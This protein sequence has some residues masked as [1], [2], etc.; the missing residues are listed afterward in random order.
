DA[1]LG[2]RR[3][4]HAG[5]PEPLLSTRARCRLQCQASR[6]TGFC[7]EPRARAIGASHRAERV[8]YA[9]CC[10]I[11]H[12]T[13]SRHVVACRL[14][15]RPPKINGFTT[16]P[17]EFGSAGSSAGGGPPTPPPT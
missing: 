7:L 10:R 8:G 14:E 12:R 17:V 6:C 13:C 2:E 16:S 15:L 9:K 5:T 3:T 4:G 11:R 1:P